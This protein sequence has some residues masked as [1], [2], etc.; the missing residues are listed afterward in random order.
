M[1]LAFG[2]KLAAFCAAFN[3]AGRRSIGCD[4][5]IAQLRPSAHIRAARAESS[6]ALDRSTT[7]CARYHHPETYYLL[8]GRFTSSEN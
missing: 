8:T 3:N 5:S 4:F 1:P 7:P 6:Y 2:D